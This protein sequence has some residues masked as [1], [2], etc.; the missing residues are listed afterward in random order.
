MRGHVR[1][2]LNREENGDENYVVISS[3]IMKEHYKKL[4][5][6]TL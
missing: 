6:K 1:G 4:E 2:V 3:F 5:D